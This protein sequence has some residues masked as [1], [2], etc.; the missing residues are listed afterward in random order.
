M[1]DAQTPA[2][3]TAVGCNA[4]PVRPRGHSAPGSQ[5]P[6]CAGATSGL[7]RLPVGPAWP[8][9]SC[10]CHPAPAFPRHLRASL[11]RVPRRP[12]GRVDNSLRA[13]AHG[14]RDVREAWRAERFASRPPPRWRLFPC[15]EALLPCLGV[16]CVPRICLA[17]GAG[18]L[19]SACVHGTRGCAGPS[20][21]LWGPTCFSTL[22]SAVC[23][24]TWVLWHQPRPLL[25]RCCSESDVG[26]AA[27][28]RPLLGARG[29]AGPAAPAALSAQ[30]RSSE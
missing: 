11:R 17:Q 25:Q 5:L 28:S 10:R 6:C 13:T 29:Q 27:A 4:S 1:L 7:H 20:D 26:E 23:L 22:S 19:G 16:Q 8:S 12:P 2:P 18:C 3:P 14:A 9:E 30:A 15:E 21:G 24:L